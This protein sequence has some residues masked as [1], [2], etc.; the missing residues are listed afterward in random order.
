MTPQSERRAPDAAP[1][2]EGV[3]LDIADRLLGDDEVAAG[4]DCRGAVPHEPAVRTSELTQRDCPFGRDRICTGRL[5]PARRAMRDR[6]VD[7]FA[8]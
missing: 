2:R 1:S 8:C 3:G 6:Q 7:A 4:D 5:V